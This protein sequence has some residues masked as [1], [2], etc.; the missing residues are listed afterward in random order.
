MEVK[1]KTKIFATQHESST[2]TWYSYRTSVG[3]KKEDGT[4]DN[5]TYEVVFAKD[6]KGAVIPNGT[7]ID[8]T[9]GFL[10]CRSYTDKGGEKKV[11]SQIV[12]MG[13]DM[14]SIPTG[15][16]SGGFSALGENDV[17]F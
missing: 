11:V 10:S 12:V 7:V 6:V 1:G 2:G 5:D 16:F 9:S 4:W 17:P 14:G 13:F 15:G 3:N 8:I